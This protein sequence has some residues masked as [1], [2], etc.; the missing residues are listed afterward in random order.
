MHFLRPPS[1]G[2]G[3]KALLSLF[4]FQP[5]PITAGLWLIIVTLQSLG[6]ARLTP[7][8]PGLPLKV[9]VTPSSRTPDLWE[10]P[11]DFLSGWIAFFFTHE[12]GGKAELKTRLDITDTWIVYWPLGAWTFF[13]LFPVLQ[14]NLNHAVHQR[15]VLTDWAFTLF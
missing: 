13:T 4:D 8:T 1:C 14:L 15:W 6:M 2:D 9:T 11:P 10:W 5:P 12:T 7:P 3:I